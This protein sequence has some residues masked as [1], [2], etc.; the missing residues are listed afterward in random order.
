[1]FEKR[2]ARKAQEDLDNWSKRKDELE[3]VLQIALAGCGFGSNDIVLKPGE[4]VVCLIRASDS[5]RSEKARGIGPAVR[6]GCPY[7]WVFGVRGRV[8]RSRGHY[9]PG[10]EA[11]TVIDTG[12]MYLT[13]QRLI[14]NGAA[15]GQWSANFS[16]VISIDAGGGHLRIAVSNRQKPTDI[17]YG[18]SIDGWV[19]P[20]VDTALAIFGGD[21]SQVVAEIRQLIAAHNATRPTLPEA[22]VPLPEIGPPIENV[23]P[24]GQTEPIPPPLAPPPLA[25]GVQGLPPGY[26]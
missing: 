21:T 20:R 25:G 16:K 23:A 13:T 11:P 4:S 9:V 26:R 1:M 6:R 10:N 5:W 7:L 18:S 14:F 19:E 8:G 17:S 15:S 2:K 12:T 3:S 22:D 24:Q